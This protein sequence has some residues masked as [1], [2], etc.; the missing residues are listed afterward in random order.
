MGLIELLILII[1]LALV[2]WLVQILLAA[3]KVPANI[4]QFVWIAFVV[5]VIVAL[6]GLLGYGPGISL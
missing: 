6:L 4:Q 2:A 1:V 5:I 3:L